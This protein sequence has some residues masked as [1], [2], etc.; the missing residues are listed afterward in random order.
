[1]SVLASRGWAPYVLL[2]PQWHHSWSAAAI[3][4]GTPDCQLLPVG[5]PFPPFHPRKVSSH[6][7]KVSSHA[8]IGSMRNRYW[9]T[10]LPWAAVSLCWSWRIWL[11]EDNIP[12]ESFLF[13]GRLFCQHQRD[14]PPVQERHRMVWWTD[15]DLIWQ[16]RASHY[17]GYFSVHNTECRVTMAIQEYHSL[18][19][20]MSTTSSKVYCLSSL[21]TASSTATIELAQVPKCG[22]NSAWRISCEGCL[23]RCAYR[24]WPNGFS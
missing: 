21:R 9:S 8:R 19:P 22:A 23:S 7:R 4:G 11:S 15:L 18:C 6:P 14:A 24:L 16:H 1:M 20:K 13:G 2:V 10:P 3:L 12:P 17:A 5:G